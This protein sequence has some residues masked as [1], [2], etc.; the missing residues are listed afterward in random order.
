MPQGWSR[1]LRQGDASDAAP[2]R[3]WPWGVSR[4]LVLG[5]PA[6]QHA[7]GARRPPVR[8]APSLAVRPGPEPQP[9][10][11]VGPIRQRSPSRFSQ[12]SHSCITLLW[13]GIDETASDSPRNLAGTPRRADPR[14][15]RRHRHLSMYFDCS[16]VGLDV[17]NNGGIRAF[18]LVWNGDILLSVS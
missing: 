2:E 14:P 12:S 11:R 1:T 6:L 7:S 9:R 17:F 18:E 13:Q 8:L 5:S 4:E 10:L 15:R 16:D 3:H